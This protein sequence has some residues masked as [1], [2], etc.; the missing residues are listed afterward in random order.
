M[1]KKIYQMIIGR[2]SELRERMLRSIV[3]VGGFATLIAIV[4]IFLVMDVSAPVLAILGLLVVVMIGILYA[5][6]K[7]HNY[8]LAAMFLGVIIIVMV[9]PPMFVMSAAINSG[10]SVWLALGVMYVFIMFRGKKLLFFTGLTA[11]V[12]ALTYW[13]TYHHQEM[14]IPMPSTA[15]AYFDAYFSVMVVGLLAGFILKIH[16]NVFENEHALNI[17]QNEELE[18]SRDAR[19][20]FFANMS[21]EIRTPINAI[22]GLNEMIMR[23]NPEGNT[24]EYAKDIEIASKLLLN[25]VNDILDLSRMES[26]RMEIIP[27]KYQTRGLI[28]DLI[29]LIRVQADKKKLELLVDIDENLP[30]VLMGDEKRIKQVLLN[31]LDNAVKYT[32]E[33]SVTL[34]VQVDDYAEEEVSLKIQV[35]DT[36][37]GIRKEDMANIYDTFMRIDEKKNRRIM[38]TGLGLAITKQLVDLM[39]GEITVDS[40]YT[41]GTVFTVTLKQKIVERTPVG[42]V[43]FLAR[44]V[45]KGEFYRPSFE[46][47]EARVLIVDDNH[48][49]CMVASRLLSSTKVQ[50]D[51]AN[52]GEDCLELTKKKFYNIIL[53]DDMMPGMS[54]EETMKA[55]RVQENGLCRQTA[56]IALTANNPS[57]AREVYSE[58]GFDGYVEKPIQ[59]RILEREIVQFLPSDIIEYQAKDINDI[60]STNQIQRITAKKRMKIC[61]T[62]D[63]ACDI[64]QEYLKQYDI[65]IMYLY[66]KTPHGRFADTREINSDSLSYYISSKSSMAHGDAVTVEEFEEFFAE[67]L[68]EAERVIH[69]SLASRSGNSYN[70]A[71]QAAKGYDHVRVLDSGQISGGQGLLVLYAARMAMEGK[72]VDEICETIEHAKSHIHTRFVIPSADIFYQNGRTR[73]I[74]AKVCRIFKLRPYVTMKQSKTAVLG[75]LY[76]SLENA[77]KQAIGWNLRRKGKICK[78]VV[79]ITHVG[80]S[81]KQLDYIKNEIL[82]RVPFE[83][84]VIQ[85]A[86]FTVACNAGMEAVA[87][88]YYM[89]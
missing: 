16:M 40:I 86:S 4:E 80:C 50:V 60:N 8:N 17:N 89:L 14:I 77:W 59:G 36:G 79:Y 68:T 67:V 81:V 42:K 23:E 48:M 28:G 13:W 5:A 34:S 51:I 76:G 43:D 27:V 83:N 88:A 33:G 35:A 45:E 3:L 32:D 31:I 55:L 62:T 54:G 6:F 25:Q 7:V 24:R 29:E 11:I 57:G 75:L 74:T 15:L 12:Y 39:N 19:N 66:I 20:I 71:V 1:W 85:R 37:I 84:V 69:I 64:P 30:V 49:N 52:S 63:C 58:K 22:I 61:I 2:D 9:M 70:I 26:E 72:N 82:K 78:E 10:A 73:A 41:K 44:G 65:K 46:A 18:K 56:V 21:H 87:I 38:G 47:P 53:M